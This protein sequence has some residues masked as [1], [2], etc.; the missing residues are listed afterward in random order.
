MASGEKIALEARDVSKTFHRGGT[1]L[2]VLRNVN[3][4]LVAGEFV[5]FV[6]A[7]GSGKTTLLRI[8]DGLMEPSSGEVRLGGQ[9]LHGPSSRIGVVFQQDA[10][11]PWL[12]VSENVRFGLRA[13]GLSKRESSSIV[14]QMVRLVGLGAHASHLPKEISGGMRQRVNLARALAIDPEV[15]LMD[16]P[17]GALDAQTREV[18]QDELLK[19]W[20]ARRKSVAFVTH[21]IQEAV[22]LSDRVIVLGSRPGVIRDEIR[23]ELPRPRTLEIKRTPAFNEYVDTIWQLIKADVMRESPARAGSMEAAPGGVL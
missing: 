17:F 3:V 8:L 5:S 2:E 4:A 22:L 1:S 10:L 20:S 23:I 16:E 14:E 12:N 11:L 7:S 9:L 21:D 6:G 13:R 19:V 15:L 18:M